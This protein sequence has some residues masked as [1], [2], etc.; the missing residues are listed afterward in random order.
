M[1]ISCQ[2][3][4]LRVDHVD[5]MFFALMKHDNIY[6]ATIS[7]SVT[8]LMRYTVLSLDQYYHLNA[9]KMTKKKM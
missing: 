8:P 4:F 1:Y 5:A 3:H 2:L 7:L 6:H 9:V